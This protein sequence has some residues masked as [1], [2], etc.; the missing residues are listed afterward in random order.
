MPQ[1][2]S[3]SLLGELRV[4]LQGEPVALP[5]SRKARALLAFL[6]ATG[7]P[8]RRERLCELFWDLPDDPKAALRWALTKLRRVVDTC[9]RVR[10][11]ADRERVQFDAEDVVIDF[12]DV[13]ARLREDDGHLPVEDLERMAQQLES[14][15]LDG[16]DGAGHE[17]FEAWLTAE[18]EDA[19]VAR[20]AV[21]RQLA[22]H[23]DIPPVSAKK[24]MRLWR[25]AD[26]WGAVANDRV[27]SAAGPS[28][29]AL[30][31]ARQTDPYG[32]RRGGGSGVDI[33]RQQ[34]ARQAPKSAKPDPVRKALRAQRI[35]FCEVSDG[36]K[37]AYATIGS[38]PPLL[39]AAN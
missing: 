2:L 20:I 38:G 36:T 21:L 18:R 14:V 26:P 31:V 13:Q 25:D 23:P 5:A 16:L 3:I 12:R 22:T 34:A 33:A 24:W 30:K 17:A 28:E 11:V 39:K 15:L 35:G 10:I 29:S 1:T 19:Q 7:R 27:P 4:E 37:I 8:H 6:A 9:D 32:L